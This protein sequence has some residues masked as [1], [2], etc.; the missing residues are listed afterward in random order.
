MKTLTIS[1]FVAAFSATT[2]YAGDLPRRPIPSEQVGVPN[3][4]F[5]WSGPYVGMNA[6]YAQGG[7][8]LKDLGSP[9]VVSALGTNRVNLES[10]G[11]T[12]GAQVGYNYQ[13]RPGDGFVVGIEGDAQHVGLQRMRNL[14][15]TPEIPANNASGFGF[16]D[17]N[18]SV[19]TSTTN[20]LYTIRGRVGFAFDRFLVYGTG[21]VAFGDIRTR[22]AYTSEELTYQ[23]HVLVRSH[24]DTQ[25]SFRLRSIQTGYAAGGGIE[26][27]LPQQ[28]KTAQ[29]VTIRVEYLYYDLGQRTIVVNNGFRPKATT[30]GDLVRAGVNFKFGEL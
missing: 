7:D 3:P 19:A 4:I 27:A 6:G 21:G 29:A 16:T 23:D 13:L 9:T 14:Q 1:A 17:R 25:Q 2:T 12:G 15:S 8:T 22:G 20:G 10:E 28:E 5:N 26:Y 11:F 30:H 24:P 18:N